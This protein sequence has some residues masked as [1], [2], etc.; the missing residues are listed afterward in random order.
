MNAKKI[1]V[2]FPVVKDML[3]FIK[4]FV[5]V[6]N[7]VKDLCVRFDEQTTKKITLIFLLMP[8]ADNWCSKDAEIQSLVVGLIIYIYKMFEC[9]IKELLQ[10]YCE[11]LMDDAQN[12][13]M[14]EQQYKSNSE[15]LMML[16]KTFEWVKDVD[17]ESQP[18]GEWKVDETGLTLLSLIYKLI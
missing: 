17:I 7:V 15:I 18:E 3:H 8:K 6:D 2:S 11:N 4:Q 5:R 13:V 10:Y 1:S 9:Q 12:N 14:T 16:N